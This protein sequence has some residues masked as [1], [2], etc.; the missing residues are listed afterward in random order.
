MH[1]EEYLSHHGILGQRWGVIRNL[2]RSSGVRRA[3]QGGKFIK[4]KFQER[5]ARNRR[6]K[7]SKI[8]SKDLYKLS[9]REL[10]QHINRMM[11]EQK[12]KDLSKAD[13]SRARREVKRLVSK[14]ADAAANRAINDSID[15]V[16]NNY[17]DKKFKGKR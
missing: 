9:D 15:R 11:M 6:K 1:N 14:Y 12:Y 5:R 16:I 4:R 13:K 10:R 7:L 8:K 17:F 3:K 2:H